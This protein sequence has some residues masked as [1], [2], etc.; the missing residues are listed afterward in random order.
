MVAWAPVPAERRAI[1]RRAVG[2]DFLARNISPY[3]DYVPDDGDQEEGVPLP[4][5]QIIEDLKHDW[6]TKPA[7]DLL[8]A[9]EKLAEVDPLDDAQVGQLLRG[10]VRRVI[11]R[12]EPV[13]ELVA[14]LS[15]FESEL[16][17][18]I[19]DAA[20]DALGAG[21]WMV[22]SL[23][24]DD[25]AAAADAQSDLPHFETQLRDARA[26]FEGL[27]RGSADEIGIPTLNADELATLV[28]GEG[29][30]HDTWRENMEA[31][32]RAGSLFEVGGRQ[33]RYFLPAPGP[34]LDGP[35]FVSLALRIG[36]N[37]YPLLAHRA[38]FLTWDMLVRAE[39]ADAVRTRALVA[40]FLR[41]ESG[42]IMASSEPMEK[43]LQA[44]L[45]DDDRV[46]ILEALR[47]LS[48]GVLRPYGS[49]LVALH[50]TINAQPVPDPLIA[51]TL[52]TLM[53]RFAPIQ[54][55][56]IKLLESFVRADLRNAI[57]HQRAAVGGA[58]E[59]IIKHDDGT[60]TSLNPNQVWGA[61]SGLRSALDGVDV[62]VSLFFGHAVAPNV[63]LSQFTVR[64]MS[65][66]TIHFMAN[67]AAT[68]HTRGVVTA[69]DARDGVLTLTYEGESVG[70]FEN[71]MRH[72][73]AALEPAKFTT[74]KLIHSDG[75][76][77]G[78]LD[79]GA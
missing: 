6:L 79:E 34:E 15:H 69:V 62:A 17:S 73:D 33:F 27:P 22:V 13:R 37:Q 5:A 40:E 3:E 41:D 23:T 53:Q 35:N 63:D 8:R 16:V 76:V 78:T 61:T 12:M 52:G 20:I 58:G 67:L 77:I 25:D 10:R 47:A 50:S 49:L 48:E 72:L 14:F 70:N 74:L 19:R 24:A 21:C 1:I 39:T 28:L 71:M 65:T 68:E 54:Q 60:L 2:A 46:A 56:A 18:L 38:L 31:L 66:Q 29:L 7:V 9:I 43:A 64:F 44:Y 57:A 26:V 55:P 30:P 45:D 59:L 75:S 36:G 32:R 51:T 42:W 4:E 11:A